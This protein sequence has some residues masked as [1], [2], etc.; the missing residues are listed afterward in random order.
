[1]N[2]FDWIARVATTLHPSGRTLVAWLREIGFGAVMPTHDG[3]E[4]AERVFDR[5]SSP[6]RPD[7]L[8][9]VDAYLRPLIKVVSELP[10]SVESDPMMTAVKS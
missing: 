5:L 10:A 6:A 7:T 9:A 3:S 2:V 8:E 4:F 1:M